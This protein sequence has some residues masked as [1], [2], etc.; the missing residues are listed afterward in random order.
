[1]VYINGRR[2]LLLAACATSVNACAG[3]GGALPGGLSGLSGMG[4]GA[5]ANPEV[6]AN[7]LRY[8]T[9]CLM[10]SVAAINEACGLSKEANKIQATIRSASTG[11]TEDTVR[12]C[13]R[14]VQAGLPPADARVIS[15]K[16]LAS[17]HMMRAW[18]FGGAAGLLDKK[19]IDSG[20]SMIASRN[21]AMLSALPAA[22]Q[23][24][25]LL[26]GHIEMST[27]LVSRTATYMTDHGLAQ[28]SKGEQQAMLQRGLPPTSAETLKGLFVA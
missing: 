6:F 13:D 24:I 12:E 16:K 28:P 4:A 5:G 14:V 21:P 23:A 8:G 10:H 9:I 25:Q 3:A 17:Q 7:N 26:P 18:V 19:A 22:Q 11:W 1:M 15:N 20:R 27:Q 2:A